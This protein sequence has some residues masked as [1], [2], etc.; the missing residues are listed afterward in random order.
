[1]ER[2]TTEATP[3]DEAPPRFFGSWPRTYAAVVLVTL[4]VMGA[5]ALFSNFRF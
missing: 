5:L 1:M 3:G 4:V 2:P